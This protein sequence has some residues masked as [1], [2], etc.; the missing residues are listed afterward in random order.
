MLQRIS[1]FFGLSRRHLPSNHHQD[2]PGSFEPTLHDLRAEAIDFERLVSDYIARASGKVPSGHL[3]Q[4]IHDL[5]PRYDKHPQ[6]PGFWDDFIKE[7]KEL[8][9]LRNNIAHF[10]VKGLAPL[11]EIYQRF[12]RANNVLRPFIVCSARRDRFTQ[13]GWKKRL[14]HFRID[15]QAFELSERD[16]E[17]FLAELHPFT[18]G[19]I[20]FTAGKQI[21]TAMLEL[22][23]ESFTYFI[24]GYVPFNLNEQEAMVLDDLLICFLNPA[25]RRT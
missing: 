12:K 25:L 2:I 24:E 10:D 22:T 8:N 23:N 4:V 1:R 11:P 9:V 15:D 5:L 14:L 7:A 16:I 21:H 18:R 19:K 6:I 17:N 20:H 3:G 13:F